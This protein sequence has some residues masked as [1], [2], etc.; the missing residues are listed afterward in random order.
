MN[1]QCK[2]LRGGFK[3]TKAHKLDAGFD[4]YTPESF[5]LYAKSKKLIKTKVCVEIPKGYVGFIMGRSSLNMNGIFCA[6][7]VIDSGYTGELG[8]SLFNSNEDWSQDKKFGRGERIA[9]LVICKLH[10]CNELELSDILVDSE[11]GDSGFGS[12]GA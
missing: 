3:P 9:Q 10:D 6:T 2:V 12:T 4:L 7:G 1:L 8:V 5:D 11:R